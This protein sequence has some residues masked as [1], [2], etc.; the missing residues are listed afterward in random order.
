MLHCPVWRAEVLL[1]NQ[2]TKAIEHFNPN[3]NLVLLSPK[4]KWCVKDQLTSWEDV[5]NTR[6]NTDWTS[7]HVIKFSAA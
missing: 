5:T 1:C 3:I 2:P 4:E 6:G 7:Q